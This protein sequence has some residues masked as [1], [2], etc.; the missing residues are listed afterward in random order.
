MV[1]FVDL[2]H[3]RLRLNP[4]LWRFFAAKTL[5]TKYR[6]E[7]ISGTHCLV[8][9]YHRVTPTAINRLN[10][11]AVVVGGN[12]T[13]FQHFDEKDLAGLK[14]FLAQGSRPTL[15]ICG[16]FQLLVQV[17]GG[18]VGLMA[19][20]ILRSGGEP[21]DTDT[22]LPPELLSPEQAFDPPS[23]VLERGFMPVRVS[24][25]DPLFTGISKDAIFYQL[26]GG[27]VKRLPKLFSILAGSD[28]CKIQAV[29]HTQ[30]PVFGVQFHPE[31]YDDAHTDGRRLFENFFKLAELGA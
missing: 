5:E 15:A 21:P 29:A 13:G 31:L 12:Y 1:V 19:R 25:P 30:A 20:N 14:E 4:A 8:V 7:S 28:C 22:P 24:V 23:G 10:P 3:E 6:L 2:E 9:H 27:E 26:H 17:H 16:G 18:E 11:Q